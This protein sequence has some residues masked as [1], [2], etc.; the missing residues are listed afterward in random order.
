MMR[1]DSHFRLPRCLRYREATV[2]VLAACDYKVLNLRL[3]PI[4]RS[5][6]HK[7]SKGLEL[8]ILLIFEHE[9]LEK[10]LTSAPVGGPSAKSSSV[11]PWKVPLENFFGH[12][13]TWSP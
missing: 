11:V 9:R 4:A 13:S 5:P 8:L 10:L 12:L 3:R 7:R 2:Q 1:G 6:L